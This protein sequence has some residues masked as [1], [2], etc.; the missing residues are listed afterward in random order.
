MKKS[1]CLALFRS[2]NQLGNLQGVKFSYAISK[3]LNL[4]K[5]EIE[6]I[7]KTLEL[8]EK[9]KEFDQARVALAERYAE[10]DEKG[11]AKKEKSENGSEQFVMEDTK[12]FDKEFEVLK[13][14]YKEVIELREKQIEEYTKLL[15][16][17]SEVILHK[18]K[19]DDVPS[20]ITTK[21]MAGIYEIISEE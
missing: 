17:E 12:K 9:F 1:E 16:E 2:L 8:P 21:Q 3:N 20:E 18:V 6:A 15:T 10:K 14:E 4:L 7:E 19:L 13:K 5:P 11:E